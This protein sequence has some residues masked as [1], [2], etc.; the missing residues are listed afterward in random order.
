MT[1]GAGL[2][3]VIKPWGLGRALR[4]FL[5]A[6]PLLYISQVAL[7]SQ[8]AAVRGHNASLSPL[9]PNWSDLCHA[10]LTLWLLH[11][12]LRGW[13]KK[14]VPSNSLPCGQ[15]WREEGACRRGSV[16]A[17]GDWFADALW[18][19]NSS[20]PSARGFFEY[21]LGK[22]RGIYP[23]LSQGRKLR[24]WAANICPRDYF[25]CRIMSLTMPGLACVH[26]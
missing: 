15:P 20:L 1:R 13:R 10:A 16:F 3:W 14:R 7:W 8:W 11:F 19:F 18:I 22:G 5:W 4:R 2:L 12:G 9:S 25:L 24:H 6:A 21:S 23:S 26:P 17:E